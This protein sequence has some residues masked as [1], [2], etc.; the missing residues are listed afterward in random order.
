MKLPEKVKR[1]CPH[2]K[3]HT[4]QAVAVAKQRGRSSAHP[5]SRWSRSRAGLRG[6][7]VGYGN[8]GRFSKPAIKSWKRKIK[9]TKKMTVLY[10]CSVC[11]KAKGIS[12]GIRSARLEVGEKVA[13]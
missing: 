10:T 6:Q 7:G 3:K 5:M 9:A 4:L 12:K 11:K 13:K 1:Y 8:M 2:C